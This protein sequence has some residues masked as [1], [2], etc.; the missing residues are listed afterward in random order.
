M[1]QELTTS[2]QWF[3]DTGTTI[4]TWA[5]SQGFPKELVYAVL[6]GR[7]KGV[8]GEAFHVRRKL[9]EITGDWASTHDSNSEPSRAAKPANEGKLAA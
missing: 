6:S 9:L 5:A 7:I 8:R 3:T 1:A 2:R 4:C